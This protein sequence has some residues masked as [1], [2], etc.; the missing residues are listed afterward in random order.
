MPDGRF[1]GLSSL[2]QAFL[3]GCQGLGL[4]AMDDG[5]AFGLPA[6]IAEVDDGGSRCDAG[7]DLGLFQ[8]LG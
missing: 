8:M 5:D 2:E 1:D 6:A 7:E 3:A 4:A